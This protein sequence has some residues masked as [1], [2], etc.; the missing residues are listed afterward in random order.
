MLVFENKSTTA[1]SDCFS[2][3]DATLVDW[4]AVI[5]WLELEFE[6]EL[7]FEFAE[8]TVADIVF[9][10]AFSGEVYQEDNIISYK[11]ID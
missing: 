2:D 5:V 4:V 6:L 3:S 1:F 7:W 8:W 11:F 10:V 9:T